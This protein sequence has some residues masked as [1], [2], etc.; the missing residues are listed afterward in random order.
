MEHDFAR[1]V[2]ALVR[3]ERA[4]DAAGAPQSV[5]RW[6]RDGEGRVAARIASNG[7]TLRY[8]YDVSPERI[9]V[10]ER[11]DA[12]R[13]L[14]SYRCLSTAVQGVPADPTPGVAVAQVNAEA[15]PFPAD[16]REP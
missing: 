14:R 3:E 1:G 11:V 9:V 12:W 8:G 16:A 7:A 6:E 10:T 15:E 13:R 5:V 4:F 2:D